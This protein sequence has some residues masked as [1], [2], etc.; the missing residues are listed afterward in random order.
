[1]VILRLFYFIIKMLIIFPFHTLFLKQ[2]KAII[3]FFFLFHL[4]ISHMGWCWMRD[5][6]VHDFP[7][8]LHINKKGQWSW[9]MFPSWGNGFMKLL[10]H[11]HLS[12][13]SK[14]LIWSEINLENTS[15]ILREQFEK[16]MVKF[17]KTLN[18]S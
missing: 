9:R 7:Y 2:V 5:F 16:R 3:L 8:P 10:F 13:I 18:A 17:I 1:M 15:P 14:F 4:F 12:L 6:S 11:S